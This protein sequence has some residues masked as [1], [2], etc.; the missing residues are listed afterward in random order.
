VLSRRRRP[1]LQHIPA[2]DVLLTA[3]LA[4]AI[5]ARVGF[6]ALVGFASRMI[7]DRCAPTS[8]T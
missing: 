2:G 8:S 7:G 4:N 5:G 3:A 1:A 6:V